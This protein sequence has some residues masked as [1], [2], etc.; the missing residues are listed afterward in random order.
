MAASLSIALLGTILQYY[1]WYA[2]KNVIKRLV[3]K[4]YKKEA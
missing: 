2:V 1:D 4:G 3:D